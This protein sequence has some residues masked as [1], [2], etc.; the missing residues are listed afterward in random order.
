MR[1]YGGGG[2]YFCAVV[3]A[4]P[5]KISVFV[6]RRGKGNSVVSA[7]ACVA[8]IAF[9][10]LFAGIALIALFTVCDGKVR[11]CAVAERN[12]LGIRNTVFSAFRYGNDAVTV[13]SVVTDVAFISFCAVGDGKRKGASVGKVNGISVGQLVAAG[14]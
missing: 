11:F 13:C 3:T 1:Y 6:Y 8:L 2:R 5:D 14:F 10:A 12:G 7:Y 9:F 4:R